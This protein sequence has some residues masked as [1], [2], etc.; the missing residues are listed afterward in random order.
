LALLTFVVFFSVCSQ[1]IAGE[2]W[3][4]FRGPAMDGHS[5]AKELPLEWAGARR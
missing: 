2:N 3:P 5:D 4:D 1:A